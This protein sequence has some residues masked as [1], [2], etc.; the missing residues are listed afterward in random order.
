MAPEV[1]M[2]DRDVV[3][4]LWQTPIDESQRRPLGFWIKV[5]SLSVDNYSPLRLLLVCYWA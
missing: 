5:L 2:A 4:S 1:L 3:W